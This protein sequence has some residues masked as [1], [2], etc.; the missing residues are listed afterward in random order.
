MWFTKPD[1]EKL[2]LKGDIRGLIKVVNDDLDSA[3][4]AEAAYHE[5][6]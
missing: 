2:K 3:R 5:K 4:K 1:I 6:T